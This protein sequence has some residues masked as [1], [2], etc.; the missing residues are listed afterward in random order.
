MEIETMAR[1]M[2]IMR[3][4]GLTGLFALS[5]LAACTYENRDYDGSYDYGDYGASA[6]RDDNG[7][8]YRPD[9]GSSIDYHRRYDARAS[10]R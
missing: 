4:V 9:D 1:S 6:Y 3:L 8:G 2:N 7:Y 5:T 10:R